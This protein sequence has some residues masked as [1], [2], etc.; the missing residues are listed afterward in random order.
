M[1]IASGELTRRAHEVWDPFLASVEQT[2]D[3]GVDETALL[4]AR[5][6]VSATDAL[7][8]ELTAQRDRAKTVVE[9]FT[10]LLAPK[11]LRKAKGSK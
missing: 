5:Q 11:T 10:A 3:D 1:T 4:S 7:I 9:R 6:A 2:P 8:T